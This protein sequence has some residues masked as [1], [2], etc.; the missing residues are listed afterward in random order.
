MDFSKSGQQNQSIS[1]NYGDLRRTKLSIQ[2]GRWRGTPVAI[3]TA[4]THM[5][6]EPLSH[7]HT[8]IYGLLANVS[9]KCQSPKGE[10]EN[11]RQ[12][13]D[14][15]EKTPENIWIFFG[16]KCHKFILQFKNEY[17]AGI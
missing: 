8:R 6:C 5:P 3:R 16:M 14:K 17:S 15:L 9:Y 1:F 13:S 11:L 7:W 2:C 4:A 10:R 12:I